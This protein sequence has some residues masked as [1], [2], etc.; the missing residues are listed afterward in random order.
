M[1]CPDYYGLPW[2]ARP[3]TPVGSTTINKTNSNTVYSLIHIYH[4]YS[5]IL[6]YI[7]RS[8]AVL[9]LYLVPGS[10]YSAP[11]QNTL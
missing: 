9:L 3:S 4:G 11:H 6:D 8:T 1:V 5:I 2:V 7:D 10:Y